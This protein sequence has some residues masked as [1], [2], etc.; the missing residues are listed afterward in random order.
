VLAVSAP[1]AVA[2]RG[3]ERIGT[4]LS[5]GEYLRR[6]WSRR[7]FVLTVPIGQL[8]AQNQ[9]SLLGSA[10]HL[11]NPLLLAGV[12]YLVFGVLFDAQRDI[13]HFAAYLIIGIFV[14]TYTQKVMMSGAR[15]IIANANLIKTISFPRACLPLAASLGEAAA[16]GA[17]FVA[18]A[19]V[20]MLTGVLPSPSWLLILP[21]F[22]LQGLFNAGLA[23]AAARLTFHYR[24]VEQLLPFVLRL[25]M[26][27]S[28]VFFSL[29]YV[30]IK[31]D[32]AGANWLGEAFQLNPLWVFMS[33]VRGALIGPSP[34][35]GQWA[36]A[37]AW[38]A[39]ALVLGFLFFKANETDY[40]RA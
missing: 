12:F 36:L 3:L 7:D 34:G 22:L 18:M 32:A 35:A 23:F 1:T 5:L 31:A 30:T 13:D 26:Y 16:Q 14:F 39:G 19:G 9:N 2:T 4:P 8:K 27:G 20:V 38:S 6:M 11:L 21:A 24:D 10:W 15:T 28:G 17:A 40:G 33:L 25:W 37:V 29:E